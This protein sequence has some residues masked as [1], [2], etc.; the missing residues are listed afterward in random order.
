MVE[1]LGI[2]SS[3]FAWDLSA[4]GVCSDPRR[5]VGDPVREESAERLSAVVWDSVPASDDIRIRSGAA[6][7]APPPFDV[8]RMA[9]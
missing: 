2:G 8:L 7:R 5:G 3:Q 4:P 1:R 9:A 6:C